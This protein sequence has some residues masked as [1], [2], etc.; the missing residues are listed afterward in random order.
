LLSFCPQV[1]PKLNEIAADADFVVL[2][3]MGRGIETNLRGNFKVAALKVGMIKH[4]EVAME[5]EGD[6]FDCVCKFNPAPAH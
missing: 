2:E 1:S 5:L 3:G 6:M 4:R